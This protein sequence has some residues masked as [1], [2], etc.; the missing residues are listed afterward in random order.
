M[1]RNLTAEQSKPENIFKE[2]KSLPQASD[3]FSAYYD[4]HGNANQ[5]LQVLMVGRFEFTTNIC[6]ELDSTDA[7]LFPGYVAALYDVLATV[8]DPA[9]IPWLE[10][11][12]AGS[13]RDQIF[14]DWLPHWRTYLRGAGTEDER[15]FAGRE[16]WAAFFL[17]WAKSET[18]P[19][20][21]TAVLRT[22]Q[23]W[24]NDPQTLAFFV[25]LEADSK[26]SDEDLLTAQLFLQQ[27]GQ[28]FDAEKLQKVIK[29]LGNSERGR[30]ILLEYAN[31]M[32]HEAFV[33]WLLETV[34]EN[35]EEDSGNAQWVLEAITFR[36]DVQGRAAW[37]KWAGEHGKEGRKAWME[38][39][40]I[41]LLALA[42]TNL[43]AAQTFMDKAM[44][45]W[46]GPIMLPTMERLADF[47]PLHNEIVGWINLTYNGA[48]H[49]PPQFCDQLRTLALRIQKESEP[50]LADW[51]KR[52]MHDWDFLFVDT[53]TWEEFI[54]MSNSRV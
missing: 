8:K 33:P 11:H 30:K 50:D 23:G 46:K 54:Q 12:L 31:E 36:R 21:R 7:K 26:T 5:R 51:A 20:Q 38:E 28:P 24:L 19:E 14:T 15:W 40:S 37:Q 27:Q 25:Q 45:R 10:R 35:P 6:R 47:K 1:A 16:K 53:T 2:L 49:H 52:L 44:Y 41:Q 17:K 22:M 9:S 4:M 13:R 48:R 18:Q 3:D 34:E 39:A 29:R 42:K 43:P 32:K